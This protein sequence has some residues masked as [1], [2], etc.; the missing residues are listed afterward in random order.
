M[1]TAKRLGK[2]RFARYDSD[3]H[4]LVTERLSLKADIDNAAERGELAVDYQPVVD[5][6]TGS[7]L[8]VEALVRWRHPTRGLLPPSAFIGLA[9]ETG[10]VAAIGCW[11]LATGARDLC[12][13]QRCHD[14][15]ELALHVNVSGRELEDPGFANHVA[16]ILGH[17]GLDPRRLVIEATESVFAD[18]ASR[19]A[20]TLAA[21]RSIGARV[22]L[23]DF[24]TG[25]SCLA[26][27]RTLPVDVIKIDRSFISGEAREDRDDVLVEVILDLGRRL[28]L[29][30]VAKGI[31]QVDQL[32]RLQTMG[33]RSGQGFLLSRP[34]PGSAIE[35]LLSAGSRLP[36][37]PLPAAPSVAPLTRSAR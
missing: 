37:L 19:A 17:A 20:T 2:S 1:Y 7:V 9:E 32:L 26:K 15:S 5:L 28:E 21:L 35:D 29:D 30:T 10:A 18:P 36:A 6:T 4:H 33:C 12:A 8:G 25:Y 31:E 34:M 16:D 13:W 11:V 23:D 3:L 24:G 22:A 27:L 14:V